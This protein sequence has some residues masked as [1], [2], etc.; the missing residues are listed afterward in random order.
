MAVRADSEEGHGYFSSDGGFRGVGVLI[1]CDIKIHFKKI[2]RHRAAEDFS[3][4]VY[5]AFALC[6]YCMGNPQRAG[7]GYVA[8]VRA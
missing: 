8:G 2:C 5:P 3:L 4:F 1:G 7:A 6:I